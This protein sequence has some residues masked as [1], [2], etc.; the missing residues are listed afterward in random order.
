MHHDRLDTDQTC[1]L[2]ILS[3]RRFSLMVFK[4]VLFDFKEAVPDEV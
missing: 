3:Q 1:G 4:V 2:L